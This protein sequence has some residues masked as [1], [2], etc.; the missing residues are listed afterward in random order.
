[1]SL[2]DESH[3]MECLDAMDNF[4]MMKIMIEEGIH[5]PMIQH[6]KKESAELFMECLSEIQER[7]PY[8]KIRSSKH[9]D[10]LAIFTVSL[11]YQFPISYKEV[12]HE[13][14]R[15]FYHTEAYYGEWITRWHYNEVHLEPTYVHFHE[16]LLA[17]IKLFKSWKEKEESHEGDHHIGAECSS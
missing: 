14:D 11:P 5:L 10:R 8:F 12:K 13:I 7:Y 1:M 3:R 16:P 4:F 2:M 17:L 6:W 15:L 9:I